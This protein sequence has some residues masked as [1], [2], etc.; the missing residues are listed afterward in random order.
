MDPKWDLAKETFF[1]NVIPRALEVYKNVECNIFDHDQL[2]A[3][4]SMGSCYVP[5]P[6]GLNKK[7]TDWYPVEKGEGANY[8]KNATGELKIT[9]EVRSKLGASFGHK[10][11]KTAS[12]KFKLSAIEETSG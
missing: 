9:I 2:S 4:D 6:H 12:D 10:L 8:C 11:E 3:D 7:R 1:L 5:I